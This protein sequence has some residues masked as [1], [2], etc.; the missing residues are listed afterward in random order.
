MT[1]SS[2]HTTNHTTK[3]LACLEV[4]GG[5]R[6]AD[7]AVELPGLAG[8]VYSSPLDPGLA[9]GDVYYFSVCS[10]GILSR[11]ALADVSG[12]GGSAS[13]AAERLYSILRKHIETWD[14]SVLMSELNEA[15][16]SWL[17]TSQ[18]ATAAV[19]GFQSKTGELVFSNAGHPPPLWYRARE[20]SWH[21]LQDHTPF[22]VDIEGLPLGMI[23]GTAYSQTGMRLSVGDVVLLY[24]DG[25]TEATDPSNSELGYEGLLQM[26][27]HV[28]GES[29]DEMV[30][31]L[32]SRIQS[33]RANAPRQDDDTLILLQRVSTGAVLWR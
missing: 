18:Y 14:Q 20:K 11:V 33:F 31:D 2:R 10:H 9:G 22:A 12:H 32:I 24:T 4:W 17:E 30:Q 5:N 27:E 25:I 3:R 16:E 28:A 13:S 8:W 21:W 7:Q 26:V 6:S 29:P 15:F 1:E 19:L 23:P